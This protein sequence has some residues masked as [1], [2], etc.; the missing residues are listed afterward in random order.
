VAY[1]NILVAVDGSRASRLALHEVTRITADPSRR[2]RLVH[3]VD[4][5]HW[6]DTFEPG[7]VG[8]IL[9]A[10]RREAGGKHLTD[11]MHIASEDGLECESILLDSHGGRAAAV[12]TAYAQAWPADLIVMGTHGR[13]G[14]SRLVLGSDAAEVVRSASTP[15]LLVRG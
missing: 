10:S 12:I 1:R 13:S 5:P 6:D 14:I 3:V 11:A 2:I 8:D 4:L 7:T 9:L 15:V